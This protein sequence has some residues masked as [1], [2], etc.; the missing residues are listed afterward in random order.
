MTHTIRE[1]TKLLARVRRIRGQVE[2]IE[3]ALSIRDRP[4]KGPLVDPDLW[5]L[6]LQLADGDTMDALE[7]IDAA[8]APTRA[9]AAA[10]RPASHVP[11]R[12]SAAS[13]TSA[14]L[15]NAK[16]A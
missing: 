12:A 4:Q 10:R 8:A 5:A 16:R 7:K 2:A 15:Q 14:R 1:K 3:R 9:Q 6:E 11:S 13:S